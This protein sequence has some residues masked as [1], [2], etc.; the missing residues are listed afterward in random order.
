[1]KTVFIHVLLPDLG[2]DFHHAQPLCSF[3]VIRDMRKKGDSGLGRTGIC[4]PIMKS[5]KCL[6][7]PQCWS[8]SLDCGIAILAFR[9]VGQGTPILPFVGGGGGGRGLRIE[10]AS[11]QGGSHLVRRVKQ[12]TSP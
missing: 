12:N 5:R 11:Q 6:R 7:V 1:M 2:Y 9:G 10:V 8:V 3:K 4:S